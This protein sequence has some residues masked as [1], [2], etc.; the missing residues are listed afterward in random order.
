MVPALVTPRYRDRYPAVP[1]AVLHGTAGQKRPCSVCV[2]LV[3]PGGPGRGR[4]REAT[5]HLL[6]SSAVLV[7]PR[8]RGQGREMQRP[9]RG[10]DWLRRRDTVS[11]AACT[12]SPGRTAD[13]QGCISPRAGPG[14]VRT[15]GVGMSQD[16]TVTVSG[17]Q[18]SLEVIVLEW[19]LS[20]TGEWL[21]P[22]LAVR[23][24]SG[25]SLGAPLKSAG[26]SVG[27]R[28]LTRGTTAP[29]P[30]MSH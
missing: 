1:G 8:G 14:Q 13:C 17:L 24:S 29:P 3:G 15:C 7:L 4:D 5:R 19:R 28:Q 2:R 16:G 27:P 11:G 6:P 12:L 30:P 25:T 21:G 9:R 20:Y 18:S 10:E 22:L 26:I 23:G